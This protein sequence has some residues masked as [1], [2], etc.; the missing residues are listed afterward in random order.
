MYLRGMNDWLEIPEDRK[1]LPTGRL[2]L[3]MALTALLFLAAL[4]RGEEVGQWFDQ[5]LSAHVMV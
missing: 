2:C 3:I 1:R 4:S 5:M